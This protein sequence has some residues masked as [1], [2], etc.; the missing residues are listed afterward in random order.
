ME[1]V[2]RRRIKKSNIVDKY[3]LLCDIPKN[4]LLELTNICNDSCLFCANS[5]C[6]KKRGI[7]APKLAKSI[8]KE[9]YEAGVREVG[10]YGTG[11]QT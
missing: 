11:E 9:A 3:S 6:T 2:I 1:S 8:L 10:F 7:I 5:K 4:M